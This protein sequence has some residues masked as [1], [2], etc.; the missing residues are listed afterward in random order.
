MKRLISIWD[1]Y[2]RC[3][4]R[5]ASI[6]TIIFAVISYPSGVSAQ[7]CNEI[8]KLITS[9]PAPPRNL[10]AW[11]VHLE[12]IQSADRGD[13]DLVL[14]GDSLAQ[15][16]DTKMWSPMRVVNL[17]VAGDRTQDVLWRLGSREWQK[18]RPRKVLII[19]GT[20]NLNSDEVCAINFGLVQV[21]KRV[22]AIWPS[23]QIGFL[24]IPPRGPLFL[25]YNDSRTQ[26]NATVRHVPGVKAI[27]VDDAITC[28]WH[29]PCQNYL[30][31]TVHFTEVGYRVIFNSVMSALFGSTLPVGPMQRR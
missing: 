21:F 17:G 24:E 6:P 26:I 3:V 29:I 20:N 15:A 4:L 25:N 7:P 22:A 31:D 8:D 30:N 28:G 19:L 11:R 5:V 12:E 16:W 27:N 2:L 23:T 10:G 14:I 18:L 1:I 9:T 13:V